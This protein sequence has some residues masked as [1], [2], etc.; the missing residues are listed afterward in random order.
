MKLKAYRDYFRKEFGWGHALTSGKVDEREDIAISFA[1]SEREIEHI[2][3]YGDAKRGYHVKAITILLR[4][5]KDPDEAEDMAM[6]I[7]NF[8]HQ[9]SFSIGTT[10]VF[11][12]MIYNEPIWIGAE[13][14]SVCQ[15]AIEINF[16]EKM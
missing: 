13:D 7:Q 6:R 3:T 11:A 4:H 1:N 10:D 12:E 16:I 2:Q 5:V 8:F 14:D 15:Y 9:R